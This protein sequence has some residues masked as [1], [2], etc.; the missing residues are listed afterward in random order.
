MRNR[1]N[2]Y[3]LDL[4]ATIASSA[5]RGLLYCAQIGAESRGKWAW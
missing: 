5:G 1:S 3:F 2:I 4:D